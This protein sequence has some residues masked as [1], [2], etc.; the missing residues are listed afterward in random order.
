[1]KFGVK[2]LLGGLVVYVIIALIALKITSDVE[3]YSDYGV[4]KTLKDVIGDVFAI[5]G[6][7]ALQSFVII[8]LGVTAGIS[9]PSPRTIPILIPFLSIAVFYTSFI[10]PAK[11][12]QK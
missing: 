1:M 3:V 9:G 5:V 4:K 10:L 2:G 6:I 7:L 12:E 8:I 11:Y